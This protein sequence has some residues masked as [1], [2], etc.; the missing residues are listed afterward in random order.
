M[1]K[2]SKTLLDLIQEFAVLN[3]SKTLSGGKLP[4]VEEG[5]WS[6]LKDF[7]DFLMAQDG[8]CPDPACRFSAAQIRETVVNRGRLRVRTD[9]ETVVDL[10]SDLHHARVGNLSCGGVLL[11]SDDGFDQ[12]TL[13]TLHLANV[14]RGASVIPT[15]GQVVWKA[16]SRGSNGT[17]RY[18]MGIQFLGLEESEH[19]SLDSFVVDSIENKLLSLSR[20]A[21]DSDFIRNENLSL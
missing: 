5:R 3:E 17:F 20:D 8:L 16:E 21:L 10:D 11:L 18:R 15:E 9:L 6:A 12:G 2:G 7:Y 19:E 4:P 1:G 13:V 14:S